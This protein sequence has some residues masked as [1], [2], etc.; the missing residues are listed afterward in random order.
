MPK[1]LRRILRSRRARRGSNA[2]FMVAFA[3]APVAA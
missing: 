3:A 1:P 2:R